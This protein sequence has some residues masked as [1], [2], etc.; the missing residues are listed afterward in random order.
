MVHALTGLH[1]TYILAR[2]MT[3][4][5]AT[6]HELQHKVRQANALAKSGQELHVIEK[7]LLYIAISRIHRDD[8]QLLTHRIPM[9]ELEP[10]FGGNPYRAA[11]RAATGL[12]KRVVTIKEESGGYTAFNWTTLARYVPASQNKEG[13]AYIEIRLNEE[14]TPFLLQLVNRF[15][16]IPL[17]DVLPMSSTNSQ[18][19]YEILWHDSF[20]GEKSFLTYDISEL[21]FQLGLRVRSEEKGK[22]VWK[23]KYKQWRDFQK[24]LS[25]AQEDFIE[26][27]QLRCDFEGVKRGKQTKQVRFRVWKESLGMLMDE[28][29]ASVTLDPR[30]LQLADQLEEAGYR[31][32]PF[33]AI[34]EHGPEVVA[35]A[36]KLAREAE[37]KAALT[38]SPINNLGGLIHHTLKTGLAKR[39]LEREAR[40]EEKREDAGPDTTGLANLIAEAFSAARLAHSDELWGQMTPDERAGFRDIMRLELSQAQ[41]GLF[42]KNGWQGSGF[43]A[44]RRVTLARLRLDEFPEHLKTLPAFVEKEGLL[45]EYGETARAAALG[46]AQELL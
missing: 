13:G 17:L 5:A 42:D 6:G 44:A 37:R 14:L 46:A 9:T 16:T 19:L 33:Q 45:E 36:L 40:K 20:A 21:K 23:E 25:R 12:L 35:Q 8:T 30:E 32:D 15:N 7:R 27:G 22:T 26:H 43:D 18:R 2:K 24:V 31:Q 41:V 34:K 3:D 1:T 28:E 11:N 38:S 4:I 29:T 10:H 39:Q